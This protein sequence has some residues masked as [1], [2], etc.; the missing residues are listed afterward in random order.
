MSAVGFLSPLEIDK[1]EVEYFI[2]R[3]RLVSSTK[4]E[5]MV[6]SLGSSDRYAQMDRAWQSYYQDYVVEMKNEASAD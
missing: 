1:D 4:E 3:I 6:E 5:V 2:R